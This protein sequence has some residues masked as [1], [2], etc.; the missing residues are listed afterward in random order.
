MLAVTAYVKETG[1]YSVLHEQVPYDNVAGSEAPFYDHL[2]RSLNYTLERLGPH[3]LPLIGRADWNDCLNLNCFSDTPGESFQVTENRSG[4]TAESVFIAGLF[5]LVA[6]EMAGLVESGAG[7][8]WA[9]PGE[10]GRYRRGG[11]VHGGGHR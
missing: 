3:G 7:S 4:S 5:A 11:G 1:D 9:E 10:A 8:G 2:R 6:K